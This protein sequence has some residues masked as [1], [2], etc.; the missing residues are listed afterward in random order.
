MSIRTAIRDWLNKPSKRE[1]EKAALDARFTVAEC[2]LMRL[3]VIT[4]ELELRALGRD[5]GPGP[6]MRPIEP[7]AQAPK[8]P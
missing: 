3:V 8:E 2:E 6:Y 7:S 5:S 4:S 1:K